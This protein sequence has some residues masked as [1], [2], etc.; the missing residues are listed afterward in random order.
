[1]LKEQ[2]VSYTCEL[3]YED[4]HQDYELR[5]YRVFLPSGALTETPDITIIE[6]KYG[7]LYWYGE[8][9]LTLEELK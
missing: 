2:I 8:T 9:N 5:L 1:M 3:C 4:V 6:I 7:E